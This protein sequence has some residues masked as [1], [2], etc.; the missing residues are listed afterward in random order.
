[1]ERLQVCP[2]GREMEIHLQLV[3]AQEAREFEGEKVWTG[4]K[5][6]KRK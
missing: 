3:P 1:M 5:N 4:G 2:Q 6:K